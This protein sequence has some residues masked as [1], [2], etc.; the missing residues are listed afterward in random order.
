MRMRIEIP[1]KSILAKLKMNKFIQANSKGVLLAKSRMDLVNL[2]HY[3][4]ITFYNHRLNGIINF[5]T[6]AS[7]Y[8]SL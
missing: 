3:E 7:N 6:F 4:I 8:S 5:Y 2:A 1:M